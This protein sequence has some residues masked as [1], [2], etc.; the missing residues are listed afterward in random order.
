MI[1]W[2]RF[3][4]WTYITIGLAIKEASIVIAIFQL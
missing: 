1:D 2:Q 4:L 3:L